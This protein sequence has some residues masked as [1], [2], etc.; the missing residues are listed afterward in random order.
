MAL[1]KIEWYL[2]HTRTQLKFKFFQTLSFYQEENITID[3]V[4][5]TSVKIYHHAQISPQKSYL[6]LY[7]S[8]SILKHLRQTISWGLKAGPKLLVL[9]NMHGCVFSPPDL[10]IFVFMLFILVIF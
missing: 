7:K 5:D 2:S 8:Q 9:Q 10:C 1:G 6:L 4:S 3:N